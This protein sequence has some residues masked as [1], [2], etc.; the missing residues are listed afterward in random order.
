MSEI[1]DSKPL[2]TDNTHTR[3]IVP[4]ATPIAE[5]AEMTLIALCDF[6]ENKYRLAIHKENINFPEV[7]LACNFFELMFSAFF[8]KLFRENLL[9]F[10]VLVEYS[11]SVIDQYVPH[12][13]VNRPDKN[14]VQ[15]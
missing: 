9:R 5:M 4:I 3:A 8:E 1:T 11:L 2:K 10:I 14:E 7:S 12:N 15:E 13:P 6:L